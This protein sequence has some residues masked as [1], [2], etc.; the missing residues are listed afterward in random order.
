MNFDFMNKSLLATD[1]MTEI[2][3]QVY[4]REM[5]YV[6]IKRNG[7]QC[8]SKCETMQN[9]ALQYQEICKRSAEINVIIQKALLKQILN[10]LM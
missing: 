4:S 10:P 9:P 6:H 7:E 8:F 5:N 2:A 1:A 3:V